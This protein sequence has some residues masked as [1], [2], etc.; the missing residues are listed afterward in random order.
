MGE[1][2]SGFK[3]RNWPSTLHSRHPK[4]TGLLEGSWYLLTNSSC[5]YNLTYNPPKGPSRGY[6][7]LS[8]VISPVISGEYHEPSSTSA[9]GLRMWDGGGGGGGVV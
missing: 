8:R 7:F 3:C 2:V 1:G 4:P 9:K 6:P 5:T